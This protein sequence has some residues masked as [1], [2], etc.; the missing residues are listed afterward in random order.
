MGM[1]WDLKIGRDEKLVL[2]AYADHVNQEGGSIYPAVETIA[3]KT[4]Y[5]QRFVQALTRRLEKAGYLVPDGHGPHGTNRYRIPITGD[6]ISTPVQ[7]E[8]AGDA[9]LA[10]GGCKKITQEVQ[11]A[12]PEPSI[13]TF[14]FSSKEIEEITQRE[15]QREIAKLKRA[16]SPNAWRG[17][18]NIPEPIRDLLDV[19]VQITGQRPS[20]AQFMDWL[21]TGQEWL[22]LGIKAEDLRTAYARANPPDG[23]GFLVTRPGSLTSTAGAIAGERRKAPNPEQSIQ[24]KIHDLLQS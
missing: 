23:R 20:K 9:E 1:V 5:C 3:E 21:N 24:D 8:A 13:N 4:G 19:F 11:A 6:A 14:A 12:A 7:N 22:E 10:P 18:E 15:K 2:L 16:D 17:R